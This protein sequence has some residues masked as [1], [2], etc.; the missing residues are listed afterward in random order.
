MYDDEVAAVKAAI[1]EQ[2]VPVRYAKGLAILSVLKYEYMTGNP[3]A[4]LQL[5]KAVNSD[6]ELMQEFESQAGIPTKP[7]G[8]LPVWRVGDII[9]AFAKDHQVFRAIKLAEYGNDLFSCLKEVA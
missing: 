2:K 1:I 4:Y 9:D 5:E 6:E 8:G 7:Y 3:L